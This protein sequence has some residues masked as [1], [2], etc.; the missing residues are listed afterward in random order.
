MVADDEAACD[1]RGPPD[2]DERIQA[3]A[4][5]SLWAAGAE[6][7]Q[8]DGRATSPHDGGDGLDVGSGVRVRSD[9]LLADRLGPHAGRTATE[10]N[11]R[12]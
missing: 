4:A 6:P 1:R 12:Q 8:H 9:Y 11:R 10:T 3:L 5:E 7:F 2:H